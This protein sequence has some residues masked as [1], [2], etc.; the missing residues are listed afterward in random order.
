MLESLEECPT[1]RETLEE[2]NKR[3]REALMQYASKENWLW[4]NR[5][6]LGGNV[7]WRGEGKAGHVIARKALNLPTE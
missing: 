5:D 3:L 4:L 2:E 6:S 1:G 7:W